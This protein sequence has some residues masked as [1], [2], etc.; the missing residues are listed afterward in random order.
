[1]TE[2]LLVLA[3]VA[4]HGGH[5]ALR[6][7][8]VLARRA[9]PADRP[10]GHR[11]R[12][13]ACGHRPAVVAPALHPAVRRP[14]RDHAHH[15]R[16]RLPRRALDRQLLDGAA[17]RPRASRP[18]VDSVASD[19]RPGPRDAVL[20]GVRRADAAVP[21][22]L[23]AAR[24]GQG[25][26]GPVRVFAAVARPLIA[27]LNGS[28]NAAPAGDGH[29]AAGGAVRRAHPAGAREPGPALGRA[30]H[31]RGHHGPAADPLPRLRRAHGDR[32][33]DPAGAL[34]RHRARRPVPTTS[35]AWRGRPGTRGS[36]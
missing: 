23:R 35:S 10:A 32:R 20:D 28:A 24:D 9:R 16:R 5:R 33:D 26:R 1:M 31:P 13:R 36:P 12:R 30:G 34:L 18:G 21:G 25:R 8:G 4:A 2:W 19:P 27:V 29:H 6:H 15:P 17:G 22:D 3:A 14:G 11:R 7:G